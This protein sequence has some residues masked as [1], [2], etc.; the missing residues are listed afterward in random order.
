MV[1]ASV[2]DPHHYDTDPDRT[3]HP[4]ADPD[5]DFFNADPGPTFHPDADPDPDLSFK[6]PL[7]KC[8]YSIHFG[9]TSANVCVSGSAYK[10]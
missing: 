7:K 8:S 3:Y 5:S 6:K 2:V 4:D 1:G 10:F 9:L